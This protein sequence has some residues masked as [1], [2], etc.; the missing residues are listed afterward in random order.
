M[1]ANSRGPWSSLLAREMAERT[2]AGSDAARVDPLVLER[3][4]HGGNL[5][6]IVVDRERARHA[7]LLAVDA[8]DARANGVKG[9][10]CYVTS[11]VISDQREDAVTHLARGLIGERHG[12]DAPRTNVLVTYEM[13][14]A[15]S[16]DAGLPRA[17][18]GEDEKRS[19]GMLDGFA[20]AGVEGFENRGFGG[21][22]HTRMI[23][24]FGCGRK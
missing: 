22:G 3:P 9:A 11:E 24:L 18:A 16:D 17:R 19:F 23:H 13:G 10:K 4:F 5:V 15:M 1:A 8:Q 14:D 6:R 2:A 12:E 20:L 7:D 21:D